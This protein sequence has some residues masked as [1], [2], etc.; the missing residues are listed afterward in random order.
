MKIINQSFN[1]KDKEALIAKYDVKPVKGIKNVNVHSDSVYVSKNGDILIFNLYRRHHTTYNYY[2]VSELNGTDKWGYPVVS[3]RHTDLAGYKE[4]CILKLHRLVACTWIDN[5][6]NLRDVDHIDGNKFNN[7]V[8][9]LEWTTHAINCKRY[10]DRHLKG[11]K[12]LII[13]CCGHNM[14]VAQSVNAEDLKIRY[15]QCKYCGRR[16]LTKQ[17]VNE[18]EKFIKEF[19]KGGV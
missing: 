11:S 4:Y 2:P 9:N 15:R 19:D 12:R 17:Y 13:E 10:W 14:G 6:N 1:I 18:D 7:N 3:I 8:D 16:V 5:P